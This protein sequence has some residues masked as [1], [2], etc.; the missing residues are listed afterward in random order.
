MTAVKKHINYK[1]VIVIGFILLMLGCN[2]SFS[3]VNTFY[4]DGAVTHGIELSFVQPETVITKGQIISNVIKVKNI[5]TDS[6]DIYIRLNY[7]PTWKCL[8]NT[9]RMY[10]IPQDDSIFLPVRIIPEAFM[11]GNTKYYINAYLENENREQIASTY[12]FAST[13]RISQWE[14]IVNP[15]SRIYFKNNE[16]TA[17]F[18]L[19]ILNTGNEKQDLI[20]TMANARSNLL[21]M[22][23]AGN[24]I[25]NFKY[26]ISLDAQDDTTFKYKIN[27]LAAKRN[28]KNIDLENYN[29]A[30]LN[31]EKQYS[32]YFHSAEPTR[33]NDVTANRYAKVDFVKLPNAKKVNPYGSDVL[34]LSAYLRVNNLLSDVVFSSLHLRGQK[35]L[36]NGG[37]LIY[38]ATF[39]FSSMEN[40]YG[41]NYYRNIPWYIGYFDDNKNL[42]IGYVN[43]GAIGAQSSGK[44]AK[45]EIKFL[46]GN[47]IGGFYAR[48]P[49]LFQ[50]ARLESFGAHHK[51][52]LNNFSNI[53]QYSRSYNKYANLITDVLSVQPKMRLFKK[54]S[55]NFTAAVSNRYNY[56]D[57]TNKF[58]QQGYLVGAG[59]TS[60][61]FKSYW[62][63]NLRGSYT[64]PGFGT[65]G[66]E[67]WFVNHRSRINIT[68]DIEMSL[69]NN[70]NQYTYDQNHYN[71]IQGYDQNYYFFNS[72]NF[73]SSKYFPSISP[74]I[75]YDIRNNWGY[76]FHSMG[77][78]LPYNKY[79]ITKNLQ[80]SLISTIGMSKIM[81][82]PDD[83][84]H[85][86]YKLNTM[87]R[88]HNFSLTG[89]YNYGPLSPAMVH[90][91]KENDVVPQNVRISLMHQFM[92]KNRHL[93]LQSMLTYMYTNMYNHNSVNI[94]PEL[95]YYTNSGWRFS[96]N[97]TYTFYSSKFTTNYNDI[98]SYI[99]DQDFEFQTYSNSNFMLSIGVKKDFGIPIPA[100]FSNFSDIGFV[101]FYDLNGNKI[102]DDEEP[103]IENV[104]IRIGDWSV[105]TAENGKAMLQNVDQGQ[106]EYSALSLVDLKGWFPLVS[107]SIAVYGDELISIP[108]VKGVK[109]YGSVFI[110]QEKVSSADDKRLDISGIK[111][112]AFDQKT[113]NTLTGSDGSF[114]FYLP[115]GKYTISLDENILNGRFYI[116]KNN[117]EIDITGQI[118]NLYLTFHI[119]EKKRTVRIKRFD[120]TDNNGEE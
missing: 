101:A 64:S 4:I 26:D 13:E 43:G 98:P 112:T 5:S 55:I 67:R 30:Y 53:T 84:Y 15:D 31:D 102:Q 33:F 48:S 16:S 113:Y 103:G 88:L 74:G 110:D 76:D 35:F 28:F 34:P 104:V 116:V 11:K 57:P 72:L 10:T 90:S 49:N 32:L 108:F 50:P 8:F 45:G 59:Y 18:D 22:D 58:T 107:D 82:E 20:M 61:F 94:S 118:D 46:P 14:M 85:F 69:I 92:F 93:V 40:F 91:M 78:N 120:G 56:Y 115:F 106:Y 66:F 27:Y 87:F 89:F 2:N 41:Q 97:P 105:I 6:L 54:H 42:Q 36:S 79:D 96:I 81:N 44:G 7:P 25:S 100:T 9:D 3:Q 68:K 39:Y 1:S 119:I 65:Y 51:L 52:E 71:Y 80:L 109:I 12:F 77:L 114:E 24:A 21:I 75:F 19:K 37:N 60:Y 111:I 17:N 83:K 47:W 23:T 70:Y 73:Y 86:I 38:N 63:L 99:G 117:Y 62:K 29:P 95:F